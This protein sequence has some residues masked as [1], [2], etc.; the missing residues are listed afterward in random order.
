MLLAEPADFHHTETAARIIRAL[1]DAGFHGLGMVEMIRTA[2]REVFIEMNPRIWGP[3]QFC[4]DQ[5]QSLLQAFIG[6]ALH[7]DPTRYTDR[8]SRSRRK[9]YFW[10]GGLLETLRAGKRPAW[11]AASRALFPVILRS[12]ASDVYLRKDS[13]RCFLHDVF[14]APTGRSKR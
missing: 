6:E 14:R 4:L 11:H 7:D 3:V 9:R 12:L 5:Q 10:L 2:D 13:W 1:R 8:Q